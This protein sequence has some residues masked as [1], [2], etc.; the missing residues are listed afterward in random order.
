M[1]NR[2]IRDFAKMCLGY[3][4]KVKYF[5]MQRFGHEIDLSVAE[6]TKIVS[7][8]DIEQNSS[9]KANNKIN[10]V[11][12][13]MIV[14]PA[15]NCENS[16]EKCI[17]SVI[18]Q[19]TTYKIETVIV[20]DGSTDNTAK[21]L[22]KYQNKDNIRIIT[23]SN[24]GFSGARNTALQNITGKYIFFLDSDDYIPS[25]TAM[26]DLLDLGIENDADI[27]EGAA[28]S[29]YYDNGKI[30]KNRDMVHAYE[31]KVH[32]ST[33]MMGYPWGKIYKAELFKDIKF[34]D[35][36]WFEDTIISLLLYPETTKKFIS[37]K[38]VYAYQ[39]NF[40]GISHTFKGK[41]KTIDTYLVT[42]LIIKEL[43]KRNLINIETE[44][45]FLN[46]MAMNYCRLKGLSSKINDAVIV[47]SINLYQKYFQRESENKLLTKK[48]TD[49]KNAIKKNDIKR[50]NALLNCWNYL[51]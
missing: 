38:L 30:K 11:F 7:N 49:L 48:Q 23:Q 46:Q 17:D 6:A 35:S 14:I 37:N 8:L 21:I 27:V 9:I 47:L 26:Q 34:P 20:N 42:D 41:E 19:K 22:E 36:L 40:E 28:F 2:D 31:G 44:R 10:K 12:D 43:S 50:I 18:D 3:F 45:L 29:F 33:D 16:I 5:W 13:L 25:N 15:Y 39:V 51:R 1:I 4:Y 32:T 24:Q